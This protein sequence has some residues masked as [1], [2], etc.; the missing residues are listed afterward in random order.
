[1]GAWLGAITIGRNVPIVIRCLDLKDVLIDAFNREIL[2]AAVPFA[3]RI[4]DHCKGALVFNT[5]N[6]W[7]ESILNL[8]AEIFHKKVHS[9][10]K[11]AMEIEILCKQLSIDIY[12]LKPTQ[13]L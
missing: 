7:I 4:L 1:M 9:D 13:F 6:P 11:V 5:D 8:L 10:I 3:C 2:L 12:D